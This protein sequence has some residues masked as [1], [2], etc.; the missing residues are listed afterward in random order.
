MEEQGAYRSWLADEVPASVIRNRIYSPLE[1]G[2]KNG[3]AST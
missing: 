3:Y 1:T 2:S